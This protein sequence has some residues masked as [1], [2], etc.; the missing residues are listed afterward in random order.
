MI[1]GPVPTILRCPASAWTVDADRD[2]IVERALQSLPE[3]RVEDGDG[4]V[5]FAIVS[6]IEGT[7]DA[8]MTVTAD[9]Q[10]DLHVERAPRLPYFWWVTTPSL[11][12][13]R[14]RGLVR[15]SGILQGR[16]VAA[17][18]RGKVRAG[19]PVPFSEEQAVHLVTV[20]A[21]LA[22]ATFG[23]SLFT[24]N[25]DYIGDSFH[26][27]DRALGIALAV[28][29]VGVVVAL[30]AGAAA[31]RSG[32]RRVLLVSTVGIGVVSGLSA[33]AP[34]LAL[35]TIPQVVSRGLF[36][37]SISI[38][39]I[40]V[41][42]NAPERAR[43]YALGMLTL[44]SNA[45]FAI[46]TLL[47][48]LSD[49][50]EGAWRIHYALVAASLV[51]VPG[52]ARRLKESRRFEAI[53][54]EQR[55]HPA[56]VRE[57]TRGRYG[58]RFFALAAF[59]FL[60]QIF[61]AP[62]AQFSNRYLRRDRGFDGLDITI[63]RVATTSVTALF[64]ILVG[65]RLAETKG[66]KPIAIGFGVAGLLASMTFYTTSGWPLWTAATIGAVV[67]AMAAPAISSFS[68]EMFPTTLRARAHA[69]L[70]VAGVT[71]S[72]VGLVSTGFLRDPLGGLGRTIALLGIVPILATVLL[73]PRL[74]EASLSTLDE[75][76]PPD[77]APGPV[78]RSAPMDGPTAVDPP[79]PDDG[80]RHRRDGR[81]RGIT[82]A[83][84]PEVTPSPEG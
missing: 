26:S 78:A 36:N 82:E 61:I 24:Q 55:Q 1:F 14:R 21:L 43:A 54:A 18:R 3:A 60:L 68:S 71:G 49:L 23:G 13:E 31:D 17:V 46:G 83:G 72:A 57:I 34:N 80:P 32:R 70:L 27:S 64:G 66:R 12:W 8:T 62:A 65:S 45:G 2:T 41:V 53:S 81:H 69:L 44:A 22:I 7:A 29:R 4:F 42:E 19:P 73:L 63:F 75:V 48:P 25:L 10:V 16:P 11:W 6:S 15:A 39:A 28:A 9:G 38:A 58:R 84:T 76:S 51:L 37:A 40:S 77:V 47:L 35:F 59:V 74:P 20:S 5:H 67:G 33:L 50:G 30:L 56:A 52:M 79:T